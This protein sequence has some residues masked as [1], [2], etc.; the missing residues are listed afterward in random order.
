MMRNRIV[1][2]VLAAWMVF[3]VFS[4]CLLTVNADEN[5]ISIETK[6]DFI[7]FANNCTLD[8]WSQGK[9]VSLAADIDFSGAD[10]VPV[11]TF[12]GTFNG[13]GYTLLG[14]SC[15]EKGRIKV[16]FAMLNRAQGYPT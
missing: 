9:T 13:N 2:G 14:I 11:P 1:S 15:E 10:F 7:K 16:C 3:G 5:T 12:G 6:E 4:A 8:S